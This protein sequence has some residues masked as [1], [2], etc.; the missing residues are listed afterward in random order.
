MLAQ[1]TDLQSMP[2]G[3]WVSEKLDGIRCLWD[4]GIT[5]GRLATE[6]PWAYR[7]KTGEVCTGLWSRY[8]KVV[9]AP[10]DFVSKLPPMPLDG[11]LYLKRNALQETMSIVTRDVPDERWAQVTYRWWD[12]LV[13]EWNFGI[14]ETRIMGK[15]F[16]ITSRFPLLQYVTTFP[17][18]TGPPRIGGGGVESRIVSSRSELEEWYADVV[19]GGGEGLMLR[20]PG[21]YPVCTRSKN[22]LKLKPHLEGRGR[23]VGYSEGKGRLVGMIGALVVESGEHGR[24]ELSGMSD[25]DRSYIST[26]YRVGARVEYRYNTLTNKGKPFGA[27]VRGLDE[28]T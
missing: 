19:G 15:P 11:E 21:S 23:V 3:W 13:L 22:L 10:A 5:L 20:K 8:F 7:P 9:H 27:R 25:L 14:G 28:N 1:S 16:F 12:T 4:G 17:G 6:V 2:L 18:Y 26:R 24:V